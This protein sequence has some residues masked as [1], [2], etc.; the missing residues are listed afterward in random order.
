MLEGTFS[1]A[2]LP[3]VASLRSWKTTFPD[4]STSP[5]C[6]TRSLLIKYPWDIMVEDTEEGSWVPAFSRVA[7]FALVIPT[8]AG[9]D[10]DREMSLVLF[11]AFSPALKSLRVAVATDVPFLHVSNL[12]HSFPRL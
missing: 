5:A 7:H 3:D 10:T 2:W 9:S 12:I 6:Y 8:W 11:H 4:P 1:L